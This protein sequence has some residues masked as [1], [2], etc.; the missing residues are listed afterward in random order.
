MK[1]EYDFTHA[2]R[3]VLR[4]LPPEEERA[5][6]TKVRITILLDQ[7]VLK[8]FKSQ[9][10]KPGAEPYQTQINRALREYASLNRFPLKDDLLK[11]EGFISHLSE[12][13][14]EY[15]TRSQ[16]R[17]SEVVTELTDS[18]RH[19][20]LLLR[21][22]KHAR[23]AANSN[24]FMEAL[25]KEG[26]DHNEW[27]ES[28]QLLV[29]CLIYFA[30]GFKER[31]VRGFHEK[32][33]RIPDAYSKLFKSE[34]PPCFGTDSEL[35]E[36]FGNMHF[37]SVSFRLRTAIF[38]VHRK[39]LNGKSPFATVERKNKNDWQAIELDKLRENVRSIG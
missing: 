17:S 5:R 35:G 3:G 11:D 14:A 25:A 4:R 19:N 6:H 33:W 23:S 21:A 31:A 38:L 37:A 24:R 39:V 9:A 20:D 8:F 32:I 30:N 2:K 1:K 26:N 36:M 15:S 28:F 7:D 13:V 16:S 12:R 10:L 29:A 27:R 22:W 18:D 34:T